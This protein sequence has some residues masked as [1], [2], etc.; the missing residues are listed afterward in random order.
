ML[1]Q[2]FSFYVLVHVRTM[3]PVYTSHTYETNMNKQWSEKHSKTKTAAAAAARARIKLVCIKHSAKW[4]EV[5]HYGHLLITRRFDGK[6]CKY[7]ITDDI[8]YFS[9]FCFGLCVHALLCM[10]DYRCLHVYFQLSTENIACST[11]ILY[12]EIYQNNAT[13]A[14]PTHTHVCYV[15][16][17]C[18]TVT[19]VWNVQKTLTAKCNQTLRAFK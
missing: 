4:N 7:M 16:G 14:S 19:R 13:K 6:H 18:V 12:N 1:T 15:P 11:Y 17:K 9:L 10:F 3:W 8:R 5:S 2:L